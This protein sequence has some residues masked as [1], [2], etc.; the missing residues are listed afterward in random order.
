MAVEDKK[1]QDINPDLLQKDEV[2]DGMDDTTP[3]PPSDP[4]GGDGGDDGG[5]SEQNLFNLTQQPN[6]II[7]E[8]S[9]GYPLFSIENQYTYQ[10]NTSMQVIQRTTNNP[11]VETIK[12]STD[13]ASTISNNIYEL[14]FDIKLLQQPDTLGTESKIEFQTTIDNSVGVTFFELPYDELINLNSS[15]GEYTTFTTQYT[16][17][18]SGESILQIKADEVMFQIQNIKVINRGEEIPEDEIL[19]D[20]GST[21]NPYIRAC[22]CNTYNVGQSNGSFEEDFRSYLAADSDLFYSFGWSYTE[23]DTS[24]IPEGVYPSNCIGLDYI[25]NITDSKYP[26]IPTEYKVLHDVNL[27]IFGGMELDT[28]KQ[29][30]LGFTWQDFTEKN[31][32]DVNGLEEWRGQTDVIQV[33]TDGEL[34]MDPHDI[35]DIMDDGVSKIIYF[36][37]NGAGNGRVGESDNGQAQ[38]GILY[39]KLNQTKTDIYHPPLI[40][41]VGFDR[42]DTYKSYGNSFNQEQPPRGLGDQYGD[43]DEYPDPNKRWVSTADTSERIY[44]IYEDL[45]YFEDV[46]VHFMADNPPDDNHDDGEMVYPGKCPPQYQ[47]EQDPSGKFGAQTLSGFGPIMCSFNHFEEHFQN[48]LNGNN[49]DGPPDSNEFPKIKPSNPSGE[50]NISVN[51]DQ[52]NV[53]Y[54][55][56]ANFPGSVLSETEGN[57]TFTEIKNKFESLIGTPVYRKYVIVKIKSEYKQDFSQ[58][59]VELPDE[60]IISIDLDVAGDVNQRVDITDVIPINFQETDDFELHLDY[61]EQYGN[62]LF[63]P[64]EADFEKTS[65][66]KYKIEH[67]F[68]DTLSHM[69]AYGTEEQI[70]LYQ[71]L[72]TNNFMGHPTAVSGNQEPETVFYNGVATDYLENALYLDGY[73]GIKIYNYGNLFEQIFGLGL[74][75]GGENNSMTDEIGQN[76]ARFQWIQQGPETPGSE[77]NDAGQMR[78]DDFSYFPNKFFAWEFD[79]QTYQGEMSNVEL[80]KEYA[81]YWRDYF[82]TY[83]STFLE[84]RTAWAYSNPPSEFGATNTGP[85]LKVDMRNDSGY[86]GTTPSDLMNFSH[87]PWPDMHVH[88]YEQNGLS[89]YHPIFNGNILDT[90]NGSFSNNL[91]LKIFI[92]GTIQFSG[93]F[94]VPGF[95]VDLNPSL[96]SS[97]DPYSGIDL[98]P[99][100]VDTNICR[101]I[102]LMRGIAASAGDGGAGLGDGVFYEAKDFI[103]G[104]NFGNQY[105]D[106]LQNLNEITCETVFQ[107]S[108]YRITRMRARCGDGST[109]LMGDTYEGDYLNYPFRKT[110]N[111]ET[112]ADSNDFF[113]FSGVDA[114]KYASNHI[115]SYP[116]NK[117]FHIGGDFDRRPSLGLFY[118]EEDNR[119]SE[120]FTLDAG[121]EFVQYPLT[122]FI[123]NPGGDIVETLDTTDYNGDS[124]DSYYPIGWT[125]DPGLE[126]AYLNFNGYQNIDDYDYERFLQSD[127]FNAGSQKTL[128]FYRFVG[129]EKYP[130]SNDEVGDYYLSSG[131]NA[132]WIFELTDYDYTVDRDERET[133]VTVELRIGNHQGEDE[134][135]DNY[136]TS[137]CHSVNPTITTTDEYGD[138]QTSFNNL[139]IVITNEEPGISDLVDYTE[140]VNDAQAKAIN[141]AL[142]E[143]GRSTTGCRIQVES[144]TVNYSNVENIRTDY[145]TGKHPRCHSGG[146]CLNFNANP[147]MLEQT[148]TETGTYAPYLYLNQYQKLLTSAEA[149]DL[150]YQDIQSMPRLKVSFWMLTDSEGVA[151]IENPE[152]P[153]IEVAVT[154]GNPDLQSSYYRVKT[155]GVSHNSLSYPQSIA[156]SGRF[157]NTVLDEWE[158]FEYS[159]DL[160][161]KEFFKESNRTYEKIFFTVQYSGVK[162]LDIDAANPDDRYEVIQGNVYLDDFSVAETGEFIPDVDVR[163][164]KGEGDYGVGDLMKYYDPLIDTEE[165]NDTTAPLEAQF[166]FYPRTFVDQVFDREDLIEEPYTTTKLRHRF[167]T[168]GTFT[169]EILGNDFRRGR[170][171]L[172]D[173]DFGD[174]SPKEF[175]EPL[176]LGNNVAVY[177]T[178]TKSGIYEIT[179]YMLRT[180]PERD[181]DGKPNHD[182][183]IGTIHNKKFTIR[184]NVNE[185]LDEDFQYFGSEN[186]FSYLPFKTTTPVVGGVSRE[187]SY[188]KTIK[189]QLGFVG[190]ECRQV[191]FSLRSQNG[192]NDQY[193]LAQDYPY[194][195]DD[196]IPNFNGDLS[197]I[198]CDFDFYSIV[199]G[200]T[201]DN[202]SDV[203]YIR[204]LCSDGTYALIGDANPLDTGNGR[205]VEMEDYDEDEGNYGDFFH[206][207]GNEACG[208]TRTSIYFEKQS[209]KLKTELALTKLDDFF[210]NDL[211]ILPAFQK[212]R[213]DIDDNIIYNGLSPSEEELGKNLGNVDLTSIRYF[214]KPKEIYQ[215]LGF[216]CDNG[217]LGIDLIPLGK[218]EYGINYTNHSTGLVE[219]N[220][221]VP[222]PISTFSTKVYNVNNIDSNTIRF[223]HHFLVTDAFGVGAGD[224]FYN[225]GSITGNSGFD[226]PQLGIGESGDGQDYTFS[227]HIYVPYGRCSDG[228]PCS[229]TD[230]NEGE[231]VACDDCGGSESFMDGNFTIR[232]LQNQFDSDIGIGVNDWAHDVWYDDI[233][234][235]STRRWSNVHQ[236]PTSETAGDKTSFKYK[237]FDVYNHCH[238]LGD[239]N[240]RGRFNWNSYPFPIRTEGY[241]NNLSQQQC[242]LE[243]MGEGCVYISNECQ[244]A[245]LENNE[246]CWSAL[247]EDQCDGN[248]YWYGEGSDNSVYAP[249]EYEFDSTQYGELYDK[250][251]RVVIPFTALN[252]K[253]YGN[254]LTI[255]IGTP[256]GR[257][258][259]VDMVDYGPE[260]VTQGDFFTNEEYYLTDDDYL[261]TLPFPNCWE[262]FDRN[263]DF[264]LNTLDGVQWANGGRAFD[265][266]EHIQSEIVPN[267]WPGQVDVAGGYCDNTVHGVIGVSNSTGGCGYKR[268]TSP[269]EP[270]DNCNLFATGF[271]VSVDTSQIFTPLECCRLANSF[272]SVDYAR[273]CVN[274]VSDSY[275]SYECLS[276]S[277]EEN[278]IDSLSFN[279]D[280]TVYNN[281]YM[282]GIVN[283]TLEG[284]AVVDNNELTLSPYPNPSAV[285]QVHGSSTSSFNKKYLLTFE[286]TA[287]ENIIGGETEL[288][289]VGG[290]DNYT[291]D[292]IDIIGSQSTGNI[293]V[294]VQEFI[295]TSDNNVQNGDDDGNDPPP[296]LGGDNNGGG[297]DETDE[298]T[299]TEYDYLRTLKI[300]TFNYNDEYVG[301]IKIDNISL[302]EITDEY[303]ED[304]SGVQ[305]NDGVYVWGSQLLVGHYTEENIIP[306]TTLD[307]DPDDCVDFQAGNPSNP[308]YWENIIPQDYDIKNR[309]PL[310]TEQDWLDD[311][312]DGQPDY[313][314]PVLPKYGRNGTFE[315]A[316]NQFYPGGDYDYPNNKIPFPID[317][318]V[319]EEVVQEESMLINIYN[320]KL[321]NNVYSDGSGNDN[322]AFVINDY[323]PKYNEETSEPQSIKNVDRI[324][325]SKRN[326]AF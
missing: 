110:D 121:D 276:Y 196:V 206:L 3:P 188:Y 5:E 79:E 32:F 299:L 194:F 166:Y 106:Q 241:C 197:N 14:T 18:L 109:V 292:N 56:V 307:L 295:F 102:E 73:D 142:D 234:D 54:P 60:Q 47:G 254:L 16:A 286:I 117:Q 155:E 186:G 177:H 90:F 20:G 278:T 260:L 100:K 275:T 237:E 24:T 59:S 216:T 132:R 229:E 248:C 29:N 269:P 306:Y 318:I 77:A 250:W 63:T 42:E 39:Y 153:E 178:Y 264:R 126:R 131:M 12:Y 183:S 104:G 187:S 312:G 82:P 119:A 274:Q 40:R 53:P 247:T 72:M 259:A 173:V 213:T 141:I 150:F 193:Y 256:Y 138:T 127:E 300:S 148:K 7:L 103:Y 31:L 50:V 314:Y 176:R 89:D 240:P 124:S 321:E 41:T 305:Y 123:I 227:T 221:E 19:D 217:N 323:K 158:R 145:M 320:D 64:N 326:G 13:L 298:A 257:S 129:W 45:N 255:R 198:D 168:E 239:M 231:T 201:P 313:Y 71:T 164:K 263:G 125:D 297:R 162:L 68:L 258:D 140:A 157:K 51:P 65:E 151:D 38:R 244:P 44:P 160:E 21:A 251:T 309:D 94:G 159:F 261:A 111:S 11:N 277:D 91:E 174:G 195:D 165:Y 133:S 267:G 290:G 182:I 283:W 1:I 170:F 308:R 4:D 15:G 143:W 83:P 271:G 232:Y 10:Y 301:F 303:Q 98:R 287:V 70:E 137:Q 282:N 88:G 161:Y 66:I 285:S 204:A 209:D 105:D 315:S 294:G 8:Q 270:F 192:G 74:P 236:L 212:V 266:G 243:Q 120:N 67:I 222:S 317:A 84:E 57:N 87:P 304:I 273:E 154:R 48:W 169:D 99:F 122:N 128:G 107:H 281:P 190:N 202:I 167:G 80:P 324:R 108:L 184:I 136:P 85:S 272:V 30:L 61:K 310:G 130:Q 76:H 86:I 92:T 156:T 28:D 147:T 262:K 316:N 139:S 288:K 114:C 135:G 43:Y 302:K 146:K 211:E 26:N 97:Y 289:L 279:G 33:T 6:G 205:Y 319:T 235:P 181:D 180:K 52:N 62:I 185:G 93:E 172:Y 49:A 113:H 280:Y 224:W 322:N 219:L 69:E 96:D 226:N 207:T 325:T 179:G 191:E 268:A 22:L 203:S 228:R 246:T 296:D 152:Y 37:K 46:P 55:I 171:Y 9:F 35:G 223:G 218:P 163:S 78:F 17:T 249:I 36:N 134:Y 2:I 311:D 242:R 210:K 253:Q 75:Y 215:M 118:Y 23:Y 214:N 225:D 238:P 25:R 284:D 27:C 265:I 208:A 233:D 81:F 58:V 245:V 112:T 34:Q 144:S 291:L 149:T 95:D 293:E 175:K 252:P 116:N 115:R 199:G 189:R 101:H 200:D 220:L 230:E